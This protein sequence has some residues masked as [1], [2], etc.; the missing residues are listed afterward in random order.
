MTRQGLLSVDEGE[1]W[2]L[3]QALTWLSDL[4]FDKVEVEV[5]SSNLSNALRKEAIDLSI[6]GDYN[7]TCKSLL[8]QHSFFTVSWVN[9]N[10]NQVAHYL[11][12]ASCHYDSPYIWVEPPK[13]VDGLL[14]SICSC[15]A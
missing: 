13:F 3:L 8:S 2:A 6:F 14:E 7:T 5:D 11:A 1:A 10:A 15:N 9:Q 4:G 12:R